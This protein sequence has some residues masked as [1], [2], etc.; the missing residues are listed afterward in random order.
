MLH[1]ALPPDWL[2]EQNPQVAPIQKEMSENEILDLNERGFNLYYYPN[3][4]SIVSN[5]GFVKAYEIDTFEW[6]FVDYDLKS[7][8]YE[9]ANEFIQLL[10]AFP[11]KP[12]KIIDSGWGIHAYWRVTDLDAMSYLRLSRRLMRLFKTDEAVTQLKQLMRLPN[13]VNTKK[14]NNYK[15]CEHIFDGTDQYNCEQLDK[16]LPQITHEDE[17]FCQQHYNKAHNKED[18]FTQ[19]DEKMPLKFA[20][21]LRSNPEVSEIYRGGLDDRSKGDWR[22]AHI[23]FA[24]GF[25]KAEATSVLVNSPKALSRAPIHRAGYA[26]NIVDKIWTFENDPKPTTL[27]RSVFDIMNAPDLGTKGAPFRCN[28]IVDG[29]EA[30]FKRGEVFGLVGGAGVGKTTFALNL[31]RWFVE[32]HPECVHFFVS[33]EQQEHEIA[34]RWVK[35]CKENTQLH[36]KVQVLGNYNAD[37]TYRHLSLPEIKAYILKFKEETG[38]PIGCI[39]LDHVGILKRD[40]KHGETQ[41]LAGIFKDLK[42]FAVETD[43]FFV[44]QSQT[45]RS[46]AGIGD[47]ELDKDAAY[48]STAFEWYVDYLVTI[49]APLK[50]MYAK[51]SHMTVTAFKYCKIREKNVKLDKIQEDQRYKLLFDVDTERYRLLTA[52]EEQAFVYLNNQATNLRKQDKK[53]D[54]PEYVSVSWIKEGDKVK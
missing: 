47:L 5:Q 11:L 38:K 29:T 25:T 43:T 19:I 40:D 53:V 49:W 2:R 16:T 27:S 33:L 17:Q 15:L 26:T 23:M 32:A 48:G 14:P 7:G 50:R 41:G 28:S 30:G 12:T 10:W 54:V 13:T 8:V 21:L 34:K 18:P 1:V 24:S 35:M 4:P 37:G 20:Q 42:S 6:V 9:D 36:S 44:V 3:Y 39:V 22:L 52:D 45:N 46:K 31:F 51:A